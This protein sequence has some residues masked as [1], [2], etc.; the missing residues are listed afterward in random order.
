MSNLASLIQQHRAITLELLGVLVLITAAF[1][2]LWLRQSLR[3]GV[4]WMGGSLGGWINPSRTEM[5]ALY[6]LAT[7]GH[8]VMTAF[9]ALSGVALIAWGAVVAF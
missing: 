2:G 7:G 6:W 1:S 3:D 5:P 4:T 8:M 9:L